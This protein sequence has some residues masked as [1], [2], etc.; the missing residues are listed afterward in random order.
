MLNGCG[1]WLVCIFIWRFNKYDNLIGD[2]Q[3]N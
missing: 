1:V 3:H 2:L